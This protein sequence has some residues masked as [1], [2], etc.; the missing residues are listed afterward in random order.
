M[1]YEELSRKFGCQ[2]VEPFK[3]PVI[4]VDSKEFKREWEGQL[5]AEGC[6]ILVSDFMGRSC[7]LIRKP[8][9]MGSNSIL[10]QTQIEQKPNVETVVTT[11]SQPQN[12][13]ETII[14]LIKQGLAFKEIKATLGL[15][16]AQLMGHLSGLRKKGILAEIGWVPSRRKHLKKSAVFSKTSSIKDAE[17]ASLK[18]ASGKPFRET[19]NLNVRE[20]LEVSL[21]ILDEYPRIAKF[22]LQ[23]CMEQL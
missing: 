13:D 11:S 2:V 18:S 21:K 17:S 16:H 1:L 22:L 8:N 7:F 9:S 23:K 5:K 3:E 19:S 4:I 20:M 14:G 6:K 10:E 12:I 15:S